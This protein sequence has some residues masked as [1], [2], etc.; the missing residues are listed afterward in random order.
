MGEID[1]GSSHA[2][3]NAPLV[4]G[5]NGAEL[6]YVGLSPADRVG[7]HFFVV[8]ADLPNA[9]PES[10]ENNNHITVSTFMPGPLVF[11]DTPVPCS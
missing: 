5:P 9:I 8:D 11:V 10:D 1:S 2:T 7:N 3:V 6:L 4:T